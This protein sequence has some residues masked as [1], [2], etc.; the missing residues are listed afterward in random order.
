MNMMKVGIFL[1]AII[2]F[3]FI[4][5]Q[6]HEILKQV[7]ATRR[8]SNNNNVFFLQCAGVTILDGELTELCCLLHDNE[9][10]YSQRGYQILY[11]RKETMLKCQR[12]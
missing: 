10:R 9:I 8:I 12:G 2:S 1:A 7:R 4:M 3:R 5:R 11:H 6:S